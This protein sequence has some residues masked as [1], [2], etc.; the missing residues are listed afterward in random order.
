MNISRKHP[1]PV[2]AGTKQESQQGREKKISNATTLR[3]LHSNT[4]DFSLVNA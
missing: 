1:I 3:S 4:G 2:A